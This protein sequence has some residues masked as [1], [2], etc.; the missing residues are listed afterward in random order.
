MQSKTLI[1]NTSLDIINGINISWA[2]EV[3]NDLR[4]NELELKIVKVVIYEEE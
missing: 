1:A 4:F 2:E 3:M